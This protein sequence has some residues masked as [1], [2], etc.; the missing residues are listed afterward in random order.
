MSIYVNDV[1]V[2]QLGFPTLADWSTPGFLTTTVPLAAGTNTIMY[3][4]S[5]GDTG[6]IHI[7]SIDVGPTGSSTPTPTP[8]PTL[9]PTP[10]PTPVPGTNV[11]QYENAK[12][13]AQGVTADWLISDANYANNNEIEGYAS[14]T[15]VGRGQSIN[16][17]VN[18]I[19]PTYTINVYRVGWYGGSG[20]RLV[21]GP[22]H[23][24]GAKQPT[25][26]ITNTATNLVECNWGNPYLLQIPNSTDSTEW[27]SGFYL[28]KL[29][30]SSGKQSYIIFVVRDDNRG[31]DI[32]FQSGVTTYAGY[33]R[34]GGFGF[35]SSSSAKKVSFNRPY[36]RNPQILHPAVG[37]GDFFGWEINM[38]RF[39]E[40]E[41]YNVAYST[42]IDTHTSSNQWT[43]YRAWL[44]VGH[45]EYWTKAM[46][47]SFEAARNRGVHLGFFGANNSYWQARLEPSGTGEPNRTVVSY[48]FAYAADPY[49][50]A[51]NF[52]E[53]TALWRN[54]IINRPEASLIGVQ[55]D[56]NS[57]DLDMVI[58]DCSSWICNGTGLLP[59]DRLTGMLGYEV[60]R[61][62]ASSPAGITVLTA[63]P[64][65]C[66]NTFPGC[67]DSPTRYANMT[68][69]AAPSGAG[70]FATGSMN[71]NFGLNAFGPYANR[72]NPKVQQITR[73]VLNAFVA[74]P[75][76]QIQSG[77][78]SAKALQG[79]NTSA[80]S[81][82]G[83]CAFSPSK[84]D[85]MDVGLL[86]LLLSIVLW[87][88]RK[89]TLRKLPAR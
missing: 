56:Y 34:W 6:N 69:Y 5:T 55:Y 23:L 76:A 36:A 4:M 59:G 89:N 67:A 70:V 33:N 38:V 37:S 10:T 74:P 62:D 24:N 1:K 3:R 53:T 28:A 44:S 79:G 43:N 80:A 18:T 85:R 46:R 12:T 82:G 2:R 11:I 45:D 68:Y 52:A 84:P 63:S 77:N 51:G 7:N 8:T 14:L 31:A 86:L 39:L 20:G 72:A 26:P 57:V 17:F 41:G 88:L 40:K 60:D 50:G 64:Y 29:T 75:A 54:P 83:G 30:G 13:A 16:L 48:R 49:Y 58:S 15:S 9:T 32:M 78:S 19:D 73:N 66:K 61:V 22:V 25:C 42:N 81:A 21:H 71:W 65:V 87:R 47:D 27:A 35:Y